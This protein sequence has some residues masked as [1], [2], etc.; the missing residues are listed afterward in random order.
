MKWIKHSLFFFVFIQACFSKSF[1]VSAYLG[2]NFPMNTYLI[3]SQDIKQTFLKFENIELTDK[4]F[5]FPIYYGI[6]LSYD[7]KFASPRTFIE[8]EFIH[9]KVYS[10][11]GQIVRAVGIYKDTQMDS[12][13]RFGDIVQNFS[14]SHG[15]NYL[16]LNVG[17]RLIQEKGFSSFF[18]FG[19]GVSIP[20]FETTVDSLSFERYELN[21]FAVQISGGL[22]FKIYKD[23]GGLIEL[24]YTSGEIINAGIFG[25]TAETHIKM[26]HLVLG[27]SYSF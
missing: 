9:S 4:S 25:G 19:V 27:A 22:N 26:F 10:N 23:L 8:L 12:L 17:Y 1:T 5:E 11:P 2:K 6:K 20:H 15:L 16:F 13:I 14:I 7:L 24:K 21:S 3:V 18:K